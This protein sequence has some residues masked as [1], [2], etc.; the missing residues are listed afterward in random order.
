MN[1]DN[2]LIFLHI[3]KNGGTTFDTILDKNNLK[4]NT[5][6]IQPI[7]VDELN[8]HHFVDL[9]ISEREKIKLLKEYRL[10]LISLV[11]IGKFRVT[12]DMVW[13]V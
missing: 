3:P 1:L 12:E 4:E 6:N 9:P 10:S 7:G 5:Y 11:V 2:N 8:V 13:A